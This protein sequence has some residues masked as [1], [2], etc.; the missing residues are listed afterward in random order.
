[1]GQ[2][3]ISYGPGGP[4][5]MLLAC[6]FLLLVPSACINCTSCESSSVDCLSPSGL[7]LG[8]RTSEVFMSS[9]MTNNVQTTRGSGVA[10]PG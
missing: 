1:M 9:T 10:P 2:V 5:L 6:R 3:D 8:R 4:Y 7:P